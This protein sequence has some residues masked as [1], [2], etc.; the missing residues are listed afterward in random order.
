MRLIAVAR[1]P[2]QIARVPASDVVGVEIS[3]RRS[4][5]WMPIY[6]CRNGI[7]V[8]GHL[9]PSYA[10]AVEAAARREC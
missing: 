9:H 7:A 2:Q 4:G 3:L 1:T 6:R 10:G 5:L 8:A